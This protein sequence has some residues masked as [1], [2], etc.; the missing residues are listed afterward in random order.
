[1]DEDNNNPA[2]PSSDC[3]PLQAMM[4]MPR[5]QTEHE[6][7]PALFMTRSS[8]YIEPRTVF[9]FST[10]LLWKP[11]MILHSFRAVTRTHA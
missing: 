6:A 8:F 10:S 5:Q 4:L 3:C 11:G 7:P 2:V 1:M 9:P